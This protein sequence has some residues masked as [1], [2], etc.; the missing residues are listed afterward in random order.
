LLSVI[1][2]FTGG[3]KYNVPNEL[4]FTYSLVLGRFI[5][6]SYVISYYFLVPYSVL[7]LAI[8]VLLADF[9]FYLDF[10]EY[11]EFLLDNPDDEEKF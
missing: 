9:R 5:F 10:Q 3:I 7:T 11:M 2:Y 6:A 4:W 1:T 8:T